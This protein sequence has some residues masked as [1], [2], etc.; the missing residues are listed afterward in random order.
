MEGEREREWGGEGEGEGQ[1]IRAIDHMIWKM[2]SL[3]EMPTSV[4]IT[5]AQCN[6][7]MCW[8]VEHDK[9]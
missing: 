7:T 5:S 8:R 2:L 4:E 6:L 3:K 1:R 9:T